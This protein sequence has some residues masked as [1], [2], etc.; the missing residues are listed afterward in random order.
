MFK[1]LYYLFFLLISYSLF[2]DSTNC[3]YEGN[4]TQY[5]VTMTSARICAN[6]SLTTGACTGA[7]DFLVGTESKTCDIASVAAN[8]DVCTY[9]SL[10]G[11]PI[12]E[13]YNYVRVSINRDMTLKATI[14]P[15]ASDEDVNG[16]TNAAC[17]GFTIRTESDN[18]NANDEPPEGVT[19]ANASANPAEAQVVTFV[20]AQGNDTTGC[21]TACIPTVKDQR[22][23]SCDA[24]SHNAAS[25]STYT[26][27]T[28]YCTPSTALWMGE[29]TDSKNDLVLIYKLSSP[30]T[31]GITTPKLQMKFDTQGTYNAYYDGAHAP[32]SH[33]GV[34]G[35][36]M[37]F[38]GEPKVSFTL[39]E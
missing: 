33:G 26:Y 37:I 16:N 35:F 8:N 6:Y 21:S 11:M 3:E 20:N 9:G 22:V 24:T 23:T 10:S 31:V 15:T 34:S 36:S 5:S 14:T 18:T 17:T 2:A 1:I 7:N 29:L 12:G 27:S 19:E 4:V 38:P 30:Y 32:N 13:T 39:I 25:D 28:R